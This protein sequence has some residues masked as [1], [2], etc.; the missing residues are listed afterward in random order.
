MRT[1]SVLPLHPSL[2]PLLAVAALLSDLA[3]DGV[4][5]GEGEE[6]PGGGR[7]PFLY[8][9]RISSGTGNMLVVARYEGGFNVGESK[10]L[11]CYMSQGRLCL[12]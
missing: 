3:G 5:A 7:V 9:S 11:A 8:A 6:A 10:M 1:R 4:A 2:F 12:C